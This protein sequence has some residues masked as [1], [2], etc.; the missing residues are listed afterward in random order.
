MPLCS[1]RHHRF[2]KELALVLL[3]PS[4]P[5]SNLLF[6]IPK[7]TCKMKTKSGNA[8]PWC[9]L[10]HTH[11]LLILLLCLALRIHHHCE[12]FSRHPADFSYDVN[13]PLSLHSCCDGFLNVFRL[14]S[15]RSPRVLSILSVLP[16]IVF[17][18]VCSVQFYLLGFI[19]NVNSESFPRFP[20]CLQTVLHSVIVD[21]FPYLLALY[22]PIIYECL[23]CSPLSTQGLHTEDLCLEFTGC[24]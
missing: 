10:C 5:H 2:L 14:W 18:F 17:L 20:T 19:L 8:F 12:G 15:L 1:P 4:L 16:R 11:P 3:C 24:I 6:S 13:P 22:V 9:T 7:G 21:L 23:T